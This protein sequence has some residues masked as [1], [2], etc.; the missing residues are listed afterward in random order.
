MCTSSLLAGKGHFWPLLLLIWCL[1]S[2][3]KLPWTPSSFN[4]LTWAWQSSPLCRAR[5][6]GRRSWG[7]G[8]GH[9]ILQTS[10][11]VCTTSSPTYSQMHPSSLKP[12]EVT[13]FPISFTADTH[14]LSSKEQAPGKCLLKCTKWKQMGLTH[15]ALPSSFF[16]VVQRSLFCAT[17]GRSCRKWWIPNFLANS[18]LPFA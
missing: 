9:Q 7:A 15:P 16:V 4:L 6:A 18:L 14:E 13:I 2:W 1:P 17:A 3:A 10:D 8:E 12:G 5:L 11:T